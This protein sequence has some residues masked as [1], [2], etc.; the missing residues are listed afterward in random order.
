MRRHL[1]R[2]HPTSEEVA[3]VKGDDSQPRIEAAFAGHSDPR[4]NVFALRQIIGDQRPLSALRTDP[5]RRLMV[6]LRGS[7]VPPAPPIV[8]DMVDQWTDTTRDEIIEQLAGVTAVAITTDVWTSGAH[9]GHVG[10]TAHWIHPIKWE[11]HRRCL[12]V[13]HCKTPHTG[14]RLAAIVESVLDEYKI[15]DKLVS[16][17]T[18]SVRV[19]EAMF[20]AL[21]VR[22]PNALHMRCASHMTNLVHQA[23]PCPDSH[24]LC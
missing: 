19:N 10:V 6:D 11:L 9:A 5:W 7:Y 2:I 16:I 20:D 15:N 22:W 21:R 18:D 3:S 24:G 17:T 23:A 4:T 13:R 8:R 1:D 14:P 12:A